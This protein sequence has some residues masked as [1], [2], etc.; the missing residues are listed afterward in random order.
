[1]PISLIARDKYG[2]YGLA[3]RVDGLL[4]RRLPRRGEGCSGTG[5]KREQ[6]RAEKKCRVRSWHGCNPPNGYYTPPHSI[7]TSTAL[8][9]CARATPRGVTIAEFRRRNIN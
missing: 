4:I 3:R 6:S 9:G 1:M 8:P 2:R 7:A 5:A